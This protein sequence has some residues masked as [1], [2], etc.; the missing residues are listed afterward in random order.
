MLNYPATKCARIRFNTKLCGIFSSLKLNKSFSIFYLKTKQRVTPRE[1]NKLNQEL[2]LFH[3]ACLVKSFDV[4]EAKKSDYTKVE[5]LI[6]NLGSKESILRDLTI[7]LKSRKDPNGVD[8][9]VYVAEI[10]GRI[11]GVAVIRQEEDIE[12]LRSTYN[13]EDFILYTQHRREEHGHVNHFALM[14]IFSFLT[15]YFIREIL[16]KSNKTSLY[17]P[18]YPEYANIDIAEK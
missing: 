1:T 17:Y 16:R 15:K 8:I 9:Q 12:F 10:L 11:V 13:I 18:I 4:R 5:R 7:Y 14:P 3:R 6:N 2:Y